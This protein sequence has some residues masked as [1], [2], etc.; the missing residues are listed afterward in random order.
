MCYRC[1]SLSDN[2]KDDE[3]TLALVYKTGACT[4]GYNGLDGTGTPKARINY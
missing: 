1:D 3:P 2:S 4:R